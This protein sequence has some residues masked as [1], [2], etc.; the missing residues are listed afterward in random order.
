[1]IDH[2]TFGV[3]DFRRSTA[4]YDQ[5]LEPLG[6]R[7]LAGGTDNGGPGLRPHYHATYV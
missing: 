3:V 2:L 1:M 7:R 6:V 5:A 4:F